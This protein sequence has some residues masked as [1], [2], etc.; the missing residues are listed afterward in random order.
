MLLMRCVGYGKY[1]SLSRFMTRHV[2]DLEPLIPW[3]MIGLTELVCQI[4]HHEPNAP[5]TSTDHSQLQNR[6]GVDPLRQYSRCC[7]QLYANANV[8]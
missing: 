7:I 8:S 1:L 2:N 3:S 4:L 6:L 5:R